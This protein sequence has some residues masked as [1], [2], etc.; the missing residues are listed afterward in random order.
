MDLARKIPK[1]IKAYKAKSAFSSLSQ[2]DIFLKDFNFI[3]TDE[4]TGK[5]LASVNQNQVAS[6]ELDTATTIR[7][8]LKQGNNKDALV[9]YTPGGIKKIYHN[10]G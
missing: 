7:C 5:Q 3:F 9:E 8:H 4:K 10:I 1:V 6:F 2:N